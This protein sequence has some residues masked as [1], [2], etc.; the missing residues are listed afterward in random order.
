MA[1]GNWGAFVYKD[2]VRQ[3]SREDVPVLGDHDVENVPAAGRIWVNLFKLRAQFPDGE[4][5]DFLCSHHAVLGS[6]ALRLVA[7]KDYP[8]LFRIKSETEVEKIVTCTDTWQEDGY[9]HGELDGYRYSAE[10][11]DD[12]LCVDLRLEEPDGTVWT[13]KSGMYMGAGYE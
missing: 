2:G 3:T 11:C 7:Y 4:Y 8:I 9:I 6:G 5:A 13:G 10:H 1:Y 12:P